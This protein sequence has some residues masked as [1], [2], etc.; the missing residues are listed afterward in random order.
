[1]LTS[2]FPFSFQLSSEVNIYHQQQRLLFF[3][4]LISQ[5]CSTSHSAFFLVVFLETPL[6][7]GFLLLPFQ[8]LDLQASS[9][10]LLR[11]SS[12]LLQPTSTPTQ[13]LPSFSTQQL[14]RFQLPASRLLSTSETSPL[15]LRPQ[16]DSRRHPWRTL[17]H[18][19]FFR[20]LVVSSC[21]I[22]VCFPAREEGGGSEAEEGGGRRRDVRCGHST[23]VERGL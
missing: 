21:Q 5:C 7:D 17:P 4:L 22:Q 2:S 11:R 13:Q 12:K 10:L 9:H 6:L 16:Q 1:M 3:H 15:R 18:L 14:Q 8:T 19:R 23:D 20:W